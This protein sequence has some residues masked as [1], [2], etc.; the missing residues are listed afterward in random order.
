MCDNPWQRL[1]QAFG[2]PAETRP[3]L[4]QAGHGAG[5]AVNG[6]ASR[7]AAGAGVVAFSDAP[8]DDGAAAGGAGGEAGDD[9]L[10]SDRSDTDGDA[11]EEVGPGAGFR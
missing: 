2:L 10:S 6:S 5:A 9:I 7:G 11:A 3:A 8:E 4:A 1:E